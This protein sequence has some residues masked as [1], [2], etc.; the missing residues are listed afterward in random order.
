MQNSYFK[1]ATFSMI[2]A[3]GVAATAL[4]ARAQSLGTAVVVR[5]IPNSLYFYVD[6]VQYYEDFA[7]IWPAGSTHTLYIASPTQ[8]GIQFGTKYTFAGWTDAAGA[9]QGNPVIVTADPAIAEYDAT[10]TTQYDLSLSFYTCQSP[11]CQSPGTVYVNQTAYTQNSD[12]YLGAGSSATVTAAPNPGWVFSGFRPGPNQ[13]VVGYT[14]TVTLNGPAV[15]YP[16]FQAAFTINLATVPAGLQVVADGTPTTT[17]VAES[18][19]LDTNHVL[20]ALTQ[21]DSTGAWWVFGSWSDGG[22]SLHTYTPTS[23]QPATVTCTYLPGSGVT[24]ITSPPNLTLTVDGRSNW[25]SYNFVWGTGTT[26]QISAPAQQLDAQ[27]NAWGFVS[28]SNGGSA[29]QS[30]VAP[31]AGQTLTA[32]YTPLAHLSVTSPIAGLNVT[33]DGTPCATPCDLIRPVGSAVHVSAPASLPV[34]ASS[35]QD[36]SGWPGGIGTDWVSTLPAG[37]TTLV[38]NYHL[39]NL[40]TTTSAPSNSASWTFVPVS[41]DGF[42]DAASSV[43]VSVAPQPGYTF[44]SFSGDLSGTSP[45]GTVN[46]NVPRSVQAIFTKVPYIG[47]TG[48]TNAAGTTPQSGV[49]P[50]SIVAIFGANLSTNTATGPASPMAQALGGVTVTAGGGLLPLYFV[51]PSQITVQLPPAFPLGPATLTV[52]AAGQPPVS[53]SFTVVQDAPGL[54]Q[55]SV[56]GQN[57]ASVVHADGTLVT[58][59]SPAQQG[60]SLTLYGTGFGPTSTPR[61]YGFAIPSAPPYTFTDPLTLQVGPAV[62]TPDAAFALPGSVGVDVIQFHLSSDVPSASNANIYVTVNGQTSN[63]VVLPVQ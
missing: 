43:S 41:P 9:L 10:F 61:L 18:W 14:D 48:I 52:S 36:F 35:R 44:T 49:A 38:A 40:L 51:S 13:S 8:A 17:P 53:G 31:P 59:S 16:I 46:M 4:P 11:P 34:N 30:Y 32:T 15:V 3:A 22:A 62:I 57:Y 29:T 5:T 39:M 47:P 2:V 24:L 26:H 12:I 20:A 58:P 27:G 37:V 55:Q 60:E 56:N 6:G 1:I 21:K 63:I 7:A 45:Q 28:W 23:T 50:G 54:F 25:A 19:G 33:V 42:Y